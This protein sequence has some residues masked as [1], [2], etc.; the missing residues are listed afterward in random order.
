MRRTAVLPDFL[1][2]TGS[3]PDPIADLI[4]RGTEAL[5]R[6][7]GFLPPHQDKIV[8]QLIRTS[9]EREFF[10]RRMESLADIVA[11]M[12]STYQTDG[13][14]LAA[15]AGLHYFGGSYDCYLVEKDQGAP[16][17]APEDFQSQAFGYCR[18][19]H[20]TDRFEAGYVSLPELFATGTIELDFH[21]EPTPV[22]QAIAPPPPAPAPAP[23]PPPPA[24]MAAPM[25]P[26]TT[27]S[28]PAPPAS[29]PDSHRLDSRHHPATS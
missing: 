6:L 9:E 14:G 4:T 26:A 13:Q 10:V 29:S 23:A 3:K 12:P 28:A 16:G 7:K 24:T 20:L 18:F 19:A 22:G 27:S 1:N 8:R 11:A 21:F 5:A 15:I 17:D 25:A 2:L